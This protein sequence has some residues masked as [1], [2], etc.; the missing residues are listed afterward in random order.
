MIAILDRALFAAP[1][2]SNSLGKA[3]AAFAPRNLGK[4]DG[5]VAN[6]TK[7]CRLLHT[8][9]AKPSR[10]SYKIISVGAG[11][12]IGIRALAKKPSQEG[13]MGEARKL[14]EIWT[15]QCEAALSIKQ[16]YGL[17]AAFDYLVAEKLLNF[18][19]AAAQHPAFAKELP[20]FVAEVRSIFTRKELCSEIERLEREQRQREADAAADAEEEDELLRE[21]PEIVAARSQLFTT[22]KALLTAPQ[23]GIS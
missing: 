16:R 19:E 18:S 9:R 15:E 5:A 22:L 14:H 17:D 7:S 4:V 11:E 8:A 20:R 6:A 1:P 10:N 21:K 13:Q 23:L 3:Y 2:A 12:I